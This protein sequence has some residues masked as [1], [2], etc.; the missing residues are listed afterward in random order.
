MCEAYAGNQLEIPSSDDMWKSWGAGLKGIDVFANEAVPDP[1]QYENWE[2]WAAALVNSV[3][4]K[5]N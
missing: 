1:Y 5:V 3:N 2:D 4:Q